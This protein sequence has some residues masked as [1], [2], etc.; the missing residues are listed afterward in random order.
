MN[1]FMDQQFVNASKMK[2]AFMFPFSFH[3]HIRVIATVVVVLIIDGYKAVA[4]YVWKRFFADCC[5]V[6]SAVAA[7]AAARSVLLIY[8]SPSASTWAGICFLAGEGID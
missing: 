6:F 5:E 3:H 2:K 1:L 4:R 7:A 8:Q